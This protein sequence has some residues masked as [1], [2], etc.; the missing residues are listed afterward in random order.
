MNLRQWLK[1]VHGWDWPWLPWDDDR[2]AMRK[3]LDE[4]LKR[5]RLRP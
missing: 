5:V 1:L 3:I 2:T 4:Q